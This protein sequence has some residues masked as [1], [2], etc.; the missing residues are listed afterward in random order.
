VRVV[1]LAAPCLAVLLAACVFVPRTTHVYDR[2]CQIEAKQMTLDL[3]Q[4]GVFAGSCYG[5]RECA[6]L[7]VA[8]GAVTMASVV[9]SGSIVIAGNIVYWF[10]KRGQCVPPEPGE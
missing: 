1:S 9:V 4:V 8:F 3:Q 10:E 2:D 5:G 7:L 6:A